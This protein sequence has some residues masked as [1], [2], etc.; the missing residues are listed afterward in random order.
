MCIFAHPSYATFDKTFSFTKTIDNL[1]DGYET[2]VAVTIDKNSNFLTT[3]YYDDT[4]DFDPREGCDYQDIRRTK[5]NNDIFLTKFNSNGSYAWTYTVGGTGDDR[6]SDVIT[7]SLGNIYVTGYFSGSVDFDPTDTVETYTASGTNDTFITK[8]GS[9]GTYEWT[10]V[11]SGDNSDQ[12][13]SIAIDRQNNLY[14]T[15]FHIST[16]VDF[17]G[18]DSEVIIPAKGSMDTYIL[19]ITSNKQYVWAK[20]L[21]GT[22][23]NIDSSDIAVDDEGNVFVTGGFSN[24][25][26]LSHPMDFDYS[27]G[28]DLHQSNSNTSDIF[29]TKIGTNGD[30]RWSTTWGNDDAEKGMA[31]TTDSNNI[32]YLSGYYNSALTIN[33]TTLAAHGSTDTFLIKVLPDKSVSWAMGFGGTAS[34]YPENVLLDSNNTL[35]ISGGMGNTVDFDPGEE[36]DIKGIEGNSNQI[37]LTGVK[38]DMSYVDTYT[39][40]SGSEWLSLSGMALNS[41]GG[42]ALVGECG[43]LVDFDPTAANNNITCDDTYGTSF[44]TYLTNPQATVTPTPQTQTNNTTTRNSNSS[45]ISSSSSFHCDDTAPSD[46]PD[47][48]QTDAQTTSAILYYV[49][50][51]GP[52]NKYFISYGKSDN[53]FEYGV[54][55]DSN[56][57]QGV[58]NFQIN[59]LLPH[60]KYIVRM[61][62]GNGCMPGPWSKT[63]SFTT[64]DTSTSRFASYGK[65]TLSD[66]PLLQSKAPAHAIKL[67]E[68]KPSNKKIE[69]RTNNIFQDI[70]QHIYSFFHIK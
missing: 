32:I 14:I 55:F 31:L 18:S 58:R 64:A 63:L 66:N 27:S 59:S 48:F 15:G 47:F 35:Y 13:T 39:W 67:P 40:S 50:T 16:A 52:F 37:F 7:D 21:G 57:T 22:D 36:S 49:P 26:G 24:P 53:A 5:G 46:A 69:K 60:T 1:P 54:E 6:P 20:T 11:V 44:L 62:A 61:R 42:I 43:G 56:E 28:E 2:G 3:G 65:K 51:G 12:S 25:F 17:D 9:D 29:L 23:Y 68:I 4:T 10:Y 8:I 19:K 33:S 45:N 70:Q 41:T 30:Y 34:D 38:T